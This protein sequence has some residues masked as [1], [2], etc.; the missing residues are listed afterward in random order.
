MN[1]GN[2]VIIEHEATKL[3]ALLILIKTANTE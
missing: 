2:F 3:M 1:A